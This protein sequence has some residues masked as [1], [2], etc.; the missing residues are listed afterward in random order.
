MPVYFVT[1]LAIF[2]G[3][4][5][6]YCKQGEVKFTKRSGIFIIAGLVIVFAAWVYLRPG[7]QPPPSIRASL[8]RLTPL[9]SSISEALSVAQNKG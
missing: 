5:A 9:G 1:L 7:W 3:L 2:W 4:L 6:V 8:L